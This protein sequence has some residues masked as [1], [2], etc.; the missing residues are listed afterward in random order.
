MKPTLLLLPVALAGRTP[1]SGDI[2]G[3]DAAPA[4]P[5][6]EASPSQ[7][8]LVQA[9]SVRE[10]APSCGDLAALTPTPPADLLWVVEHVRSPPWAGMKAAECLVLAHP[11]A[12]RTA[13]DAWVTDPRLKGL[14]W[15]VLKHL[16][17]MPRPLALELAR[18]AITDGPD[19][20]G[21]KRRIRR[22]GVPEIQALGAE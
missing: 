18:R 14:G 22:S 17:A 1:P 13:L 11:D 15:V 6:A 9:L 3:P 4:L 8:A 12:A 16:D 21:E 10:P 19:P 5:A 20:D 2:E 7:E